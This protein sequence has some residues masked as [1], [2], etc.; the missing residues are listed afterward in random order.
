MDRNLEQIVGLMSKERRTL[1]ELKINFS[2]VK[3]L[4]K[5]GFNVK[6]SNGFYWIKSMDQDN[7][8]V[9]S[10]LNK[11][12]SKLSWA[13]VSDIHAGAKTFDE[14]G[15]RWFLQQVKDRGIKYV[16][17]SGDAVDGTK[18]YPGQVNYLKY[19][20]EE[21]QVNC[22]GDLIGEFENDFKW[23]M[24][25]GNHDMSWVK[26]GAPSPNKLLSNK[27]KNVVYLPGAGADKIV[28]GDIILDGVMK[29][30]VH[31]WS[32]SARGTYALSYPGQVYLRNV[33]GNDVQFEVSGKKYFMKLL[34]IGHYHTEMMYRSFGVRVTHPL[35]FQKPNDYTEGMGKVGPRGGRITEM[36][37]KN[38]E[39][40]Y[41]NSEV[42]EVPNL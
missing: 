29:R 26:L 3:E 1:K 11:E 41:Y 12:Q 20:S 40:L 6:S 31:P 19:F 25:D 13:E 21:D 27:L 4:K 14:K 37:V 2:D 35:S 18:V 7:H 42:L 8:Y 39:I 34:Q 10:P 33:M 17:F 36:D 9:V 23:L 15:F 28:R 5:L 22:L 32:N 24:I 38:G 30:M 16:H